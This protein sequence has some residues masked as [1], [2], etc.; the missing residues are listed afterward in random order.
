MTS[1]LVTESNIKIL[2]ECLNVRRTSLRTD[3]SLQASIVH[4]AAEYEEFRSYGGP[5]AINRVL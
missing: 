3:Q 2:S 4:R 5:C 1:R